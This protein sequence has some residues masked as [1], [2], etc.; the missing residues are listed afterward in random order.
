MTD[1]REDASFVERFVGAGLGVVVEEAVALGD[2]SRR[3]ALGLWRGQP[4]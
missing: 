2:D 4:V 1:S 3:C